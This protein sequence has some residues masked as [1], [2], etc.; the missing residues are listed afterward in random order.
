VT[1]TRGFAASDVAGADCLI[2]DEPRFAGLVVQ[3]NCKVIYRATDL[4]A[5]LR[6]DPKIIDAE[7][8]MCERAEVLVA[9]SEPVARHLRAL[10]G[11]PV[12]VITNGV[13]FARFCVDSGTAAGLPLPGH[14]NQRAV[15]VGAFDARFSRTALKAAALAHSEKYFVLAGP[16]SQSFAN[17]LALQNVVGLGAIPYARVAALLQ[18]C[19]VGLLP[20]AIGAANEG[21]S[22]MKLY[23]YA[24]AGMTVAALATSELTRRTLP[25]LCTCAT[26]DEFPLA[27]AA[28][29]DLSA[30]TTV[31]TEARAQAELHSWIAKANELLALI[32][33]PR[34]PSALSRVSQTPQGVAP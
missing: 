11:K 18:Q 31:V 22:P 34:A 15:Y 20:L 12:S 8:V 6:N 25:T 32:N 14:R 10:S 3:A 24:A 21:R 27:V 7:R 23:E 33:A 17:V 16:G 5:E 2:V 30:N 29:F 9:T 28:A 26:E 13:D 19:A 1:P 4:Y